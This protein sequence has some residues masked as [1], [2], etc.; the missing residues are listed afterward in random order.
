MFI[1]ILKLIQFIIISVLFNFIILL[2]NFRAKSKTSGNAKELAIYVNPWFLTKTPYFL[3]SLSLLLAKH[4]YKINI[5]F[6]DFQIFK[7]NKYIVTITNFFIL[8]NCKFLKLLEKKIQIVIIKKVKS[9]KIKINNRTKI[10]L[11][12]LIK[13]NIYRLTRNEDEF[14]KWNLK[15]HELSKEI[16]KRYSQ[17]ITYIQSNKEKFYIIPGGIA[18][19]TGIYSNYLKKKKIDFLTIDN[20]KTNKKFFLFLCLNGIAAKR[21]DGFNAFSKTKRKLNFIKIK[22]YVNSEINKRSK[23]K[24]NLNFQS[25]AIKSINKKDYILILLSSGWD[26]SSLMTHKIFK[27]NKAWLKETLE[28]IAKNYKNQKILIREHPHLRIKEF[29]S[30]DNFHEIYNEFKNVEIIDSYSKLN[31]YKL[32]KK[33]KFIITTVST[34]GI[35]ASILKKNSIFV[36]KCIYEKFNFF[37]DIKTK[38]DYFGE[39]AKLQ[40]NNK[41]SNKYQKRAINCYF[42]CDYLKMVET[43]YCPDY[44]TFSPIKLKEILDSI[45]LDLIVKI[46]NNVKPFPYINLKYNLKKNV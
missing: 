5:I 13:A 11:K 45:S 18:N 21:E 40:K 29:K 33:S 4:N 37:K 6:D 23:G 12:E 31:T 22:N 36:G 41:F 20:A 7:K 15:N 35:E 10:Y 17:I 8:L 34:S 39:I 30:N 28:W 38:K 43:K 32:I 1:S 14:V 19:T 24:D 46:I 3:M 9:K 26:S 25:N 16:I 27:D 2:I 42:F 44:M